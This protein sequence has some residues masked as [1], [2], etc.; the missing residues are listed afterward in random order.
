MQRLCQCFVGVL[1]FFGGDVFLD[2]LVVL[3]RFAI[4]DCDFF[5]KKIIFVKSCQNGVVTLRRE[6]NMEDYETMFELWLCR[7]K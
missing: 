5:V 7:K 4:L 2:V 6:I 1:Y 3:D